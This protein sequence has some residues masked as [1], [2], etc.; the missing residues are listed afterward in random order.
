MKGTVRAGAGTTQR[1]LLD[2]AGVL[3]G[4]EGIDGIPVQPPLPEG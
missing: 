2:L 1:E 4:R 3:N